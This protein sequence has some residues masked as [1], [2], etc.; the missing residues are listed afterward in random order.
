MNDSPTSTRLASVVERVTLRA[1]S[2]SESSR[3]PR[4]RG[5]SQA[6]PGANRRRPQASSSG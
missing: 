2:T 4:H 3:R 6:A 1:I 5:P